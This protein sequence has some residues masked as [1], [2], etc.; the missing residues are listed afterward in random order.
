SLILSFGF[1]SIAI[2]LAIFTWGHILNVLGKPI[3]WQEHFY[4]YC[5]SNLSRRLPAP[6]AHIGTRLI[7]YDHE[8]AI[9]SAVSSGSILEMTLMGLSGL[10]VSVMTGTLKEN[11]LL[12][13]ITTLVIIGSL[14]LLCCLL[15]FY[16]AKRRQISLNG[17]N[18]SIWHL[19]GWF[20]AYGSLWCIGGASFYFIVRALWDISKADI[21]TII[22]A[23]TVSGL[24]AL[25]AAVMPVGLGLRELTL[26]LLLT[27]ILP[28]G[29]AIIIAVI[30]RLVFMLYELLWVLLSHL[31]I[32]NPR[33]LH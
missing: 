28:Q 7:L 2:V 24:V 1:Y 19:A 22:N 9:M 18:L 16:W 10:F 15:A 33:I 12:V 5:I 14:L 6:M 27:D 17:K 11:H 26:G 21:G 3:S 30:S 23:W 8:A 13:R 25:I 4:N 31:L 20:L 32:K 29:A